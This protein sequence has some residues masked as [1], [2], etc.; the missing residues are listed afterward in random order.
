VLFARY[1]IAIFVVLL[2]EGTVGQRIA[3]L[4]IHP[5]LGLALVVYA[6]LFHGRPVGVGVGFLMGLLRGCLEPEWF[7]L[8]ALLM[9]WVAFAAGSTS[10]VLN[11]SHPYLQAFLIGLLILAHDLVRAFIVASA[12]PTDA[13]T[14]WASRSPLTALYTAVVVPLAVLWVPPLFAGRDRRASR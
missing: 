11:R 8:E 2:L 4:G 14:L 12:V 3:I 6:G 1:L 9:P 13:L 5:D 10:A 7:G